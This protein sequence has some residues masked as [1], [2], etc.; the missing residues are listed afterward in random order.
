M[1]REMAETV[2]NGVTPLPVSAGGAGGGGGGGS[3]SAMVVK[4][5]LV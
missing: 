3:A 2:L 1:K 5:G 4:R